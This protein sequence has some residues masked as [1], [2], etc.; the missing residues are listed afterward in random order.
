M[1]SRHGGICCEAVGTQQVSRLKC[2][3][4]LLEMDCTRPLSLTHDDLTNSLLTVTSE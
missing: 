4:R 2:G 3:M 1:V